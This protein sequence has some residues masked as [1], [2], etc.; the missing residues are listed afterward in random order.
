MT[1]EWATEALRAHQRVDA[2]A[3]T[4]LALAKHEEGAEAAFKDTEA[5]VERML[6]AVLA[7]ERAAARQPANGSGEDPA[8]HPAGPDGA[9]EHPVHPA[10]PGAVERMLAWAEGRWADEQVGALRSA[11]KT[12][13]DAAGRQEGGDALVALRAYAAWLRDVRQGVRAAAKPRP[14]GATP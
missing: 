1:T 3:G 11:W 7:V 14:R 2:V 9:E 13:S 10:G 6:R 8:T 4:R 12:A 5:R